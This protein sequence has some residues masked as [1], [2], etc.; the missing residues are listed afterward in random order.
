L[1]WLPALHGI[2]CSSVSLTEWLKNNQAIFNIRTSVSIALLRKQR[3]LQ[4]SEQ[5]K[6]PP[7]PAFCALV[8]LKKLLH[9]ESQSSHKVHRVLCVTSWILCEALCR[10]LVNIKI[11]K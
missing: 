4:N 2:V 11:K 10:E 9:E 8:L 6:N 5:M 1:G 3:T 7:R